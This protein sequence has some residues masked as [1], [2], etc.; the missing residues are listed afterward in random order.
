MD[1]CA[2]FGIGMI[3]K[4]KKN[5]AGASLTGQSGKAGREMALPAET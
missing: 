1:A 2:F 4:G 3:A 5:P